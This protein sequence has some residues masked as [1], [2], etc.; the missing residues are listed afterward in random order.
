M[1]NGFT[2][3]YG[4]VNQLDSNKNLKKNE[5]D[6]QPQFLWREFVVYVVLVDKKI[7]AGCYYLITQLCL[8]LCGPMDCS[9]PGS[10]V[11]G[12]LQKRRLEQAA[13]SYSRV[14]SWPRDRTHISCVVSFIVKWILYHWATWEAPVA[15][16]TVM[17]S[18]GCVSTGLVQRV[19]ACIRSVDSIREH[20][21]ITGSRMVCRYVINT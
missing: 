17:S 6:N 2:L 3:L 1:Y 16:S 12:I 11:H 13:I 4:I 5:N 18:L 10:P 15:S 9:P 8:T 14:S 19:A 20:Q 21:S 7:K